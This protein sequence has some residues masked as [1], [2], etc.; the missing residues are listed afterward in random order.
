MKSLQ[1]EYHKICNQYLLEFCKKH[2]WD[3]EFWVAD[4]PGTIA[5][6][7][8]YFIGFREMRYDIDNNIKEDA[9]IK[10]YDYALGLG[11]KDEFYLL[12]E[13]WCK[14]TNNGANSLP[15]KLST[16]VDL[17]VPE[18]LKDAARRLKMLLR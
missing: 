7:G 17:K 16:S 11:M 18:T 13:N 1:K 4:E 5:I 12:Y 2:E 9:F 15:D 10:W 14:V 6:I 8:D 3:F